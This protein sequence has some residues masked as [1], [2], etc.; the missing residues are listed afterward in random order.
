[1]MNHWLLASFLGGATLLGGFAAA[2]TAGVTVVQNDR[3]FQPESIEIAK[4]TVVHFA[5]EDEFIHQ[6]YVKSPTMNFDSA[7]QVPGDNIDIEFDEAGRFAVRCHIHPK[8]HLEVTV[9]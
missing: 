6:I 8:M 2:A 7:E 3:S 1:M 4:G 9:K 5:N